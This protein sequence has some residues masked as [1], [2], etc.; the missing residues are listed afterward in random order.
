MGLSYWITIPIF[1]TNLKISTIHELYS[2]T[3]FLRTDLAIRIAQTPGPYKL[4]FI[5]EGSLVP[6]LTTENDA[7]C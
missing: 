2:S 6:F 1:F 3:D 5:L 4:I 7:C